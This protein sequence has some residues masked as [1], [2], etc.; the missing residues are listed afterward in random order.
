MC[1]N[2]PGEFR[3]HKLTLRM[4]KH[5]TA[6]TVTDFPRSLKSF[7]NNRRVVP[8]QFVCTCNNKDSDDNMQPLLT[9][10]SVPV[11]AKCLMC[12]ITFNPHYN[13]KR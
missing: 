13:P 4:E 9:A 5:L 10:C 2:C 11:T 3:H 7:A 12:I 8:F 1:F 6:F